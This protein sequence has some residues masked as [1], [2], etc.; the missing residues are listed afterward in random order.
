MA[1]IPTHLSSY[2]L[3]FSKWQRKMMK[4][5]DDISPYTFVSLCTRLLMMVRKDGEKE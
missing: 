1:S 2:V 5:D 3:D 4:K